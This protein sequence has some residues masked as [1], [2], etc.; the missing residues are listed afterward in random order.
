MDQAPRCASCASPHLGLP[1][2]ALPFPLS[3]ASMKEG[4]APVLSPSKRAR[5]ASRSSSAMPMGV[6]VVKLFCRSSKPD[7]TLPWKSNR[8][9]SSFSTAF[10]FSAES[11]LLLTNRHCVSHCVSLEARRRGDH[12]KFEARILARGVDCD[13]ALLTVDAPAFWEGS[14]ATSELLLRLDPPELFTEIMCVGYPTGG[15]T[16][17]VTKG[18][19]SRV[20]SEDT[21]D[22][23]QSRQV[24]QIDAAIN[25]GN[26][27]GPAIGTD[28]TCVGVAYESLSRE[29]TENIGYIVP[30]A[31]VRKFIA[32]WKR[33]GGARTCGAVAD[34]RAF[35]HGGFETQPVQNPSLREHLGLPDDKSGV[36]VTRVSRACSHAKGLRAGDVLLQF[37]GYDLGEDGSVSLDGTPDRVPFPFAVASRFIGDEIDAVV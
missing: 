28:G 36:L 4:T 19:V 12:R 21:H 20:D 5:V 30:A 13:L 3:A 37:G 11:R 25:P 27:G 18:V 15:D 34:V 6:A 32:A 29:D 23:W 1:R 9:D 7:Y 26:S 14:G 2:R 10:V 24:V 33:V 8:I 31:V 17:C 16:L 22:T 35:G